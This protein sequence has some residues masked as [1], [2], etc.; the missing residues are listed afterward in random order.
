MLLRLLGLALLLECAGCAWLPTRTEADRAAALDLIDHAV[1]QLEAG[2]VE[3]AEASFAMAFERYP[4]AAALDG[5]GCAQ[6]Y[7][8]DLP[9]AKEFFTLARSLDPEYYTALG[10]LAGVAELQGDRAKAERL[11]REALFYEPQNI[12]TRNNF[13]AFLF[14]N[15]RGRDLTQVRRELLRANSIARLAVVQENF[16]KVDD[17]YER[18]Q[19][20]NSTAQ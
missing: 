4:L 14:E 7:A 16:S 1:V 17:N 18:K 8:G 15:L 9:Q 11:Y 5:M 6:L 10:H 2:F 13:A 3:Q 12:R 19:E 20:A